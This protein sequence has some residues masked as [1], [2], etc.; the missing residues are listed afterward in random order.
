[1]KLSIVKSRLASIPVPANIDVLSRTFPEVIVRHLGSGMQRHAY[2]I[3][4]YVVKANTG[5]F[6]AGWDDAYRAEV[7]CRVPRKALASVGLQAPASWYAGPNR[8]WVIQQYCDARPRTPEF[9]KLIQATCAR[10]DVCGAVRWQ[11]TR[12]PSSRVYLDLHPGNLGMHPKTGRVVA[13]DW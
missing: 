7:Y 6:H 8:V 11:I 12:S 4:P 1:M 10:L 3:G 5:S 2:Q 9:A 13:F